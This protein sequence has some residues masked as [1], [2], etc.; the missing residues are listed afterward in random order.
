MLKDLKE[1]K[2]MFL[3]LVLLYNDKIDE[4]LF[5]QKSIIKYLSV[6]N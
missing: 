2:G 1:D 5:Y 4:Y 3:V 6:I